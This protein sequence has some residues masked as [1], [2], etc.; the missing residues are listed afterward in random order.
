VVGGEAEEGGIEVGAKAARNIEGE[1]LESPLGR[2]EGVVSRAEAGSGGA[3]LP[4]SRGA[5]GKGEG[6]GDG[7]GEGG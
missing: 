2:G 3:T 4:G 7:C 6:V 5:R 1:E